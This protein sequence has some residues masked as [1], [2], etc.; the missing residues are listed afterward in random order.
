VTA[1]AGDAQLAASPLLA[2]THF[3]ITPNSGASL[4]PNETPEKDQ[5]HQRDLAPPGERS[6]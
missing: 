4:G 1:R 6:A 2:N 3:P 5:Q